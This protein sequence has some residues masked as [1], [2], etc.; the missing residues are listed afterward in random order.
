MKTKLDFLISPSSVASITTI[1]SIVPS[2]VEEKIFIL[3]WKQ[4]MDE[5]RSRKF[6]QSLGIYF[7]TAVLVKN[8]LTC[9]T[10]TLN[11]LHLLR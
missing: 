8:V 10:S 2:V 3:R 5:P 4:Q 11:L 6:K 9:P 1:I 7:L